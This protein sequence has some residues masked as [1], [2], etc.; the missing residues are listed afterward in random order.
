VK[1]HSNYFEKF[2]WSVADF[3]EDALSWIARIGVQ[4]L[5]LSYPISSYTGLCYNGGLLYWL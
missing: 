1:P 3:V 4:V 2:D 5:T